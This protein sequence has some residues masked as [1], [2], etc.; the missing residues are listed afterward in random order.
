MNK[1]ELKVMNQRRMN[2]I[3]DHDSGKS[4]GTKS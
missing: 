1:E 2:T 4:R 3:K